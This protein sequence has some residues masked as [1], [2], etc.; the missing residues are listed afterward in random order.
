[1]PMHEHNRG[2]HAA[3]TDTERDLAD[4][5]EVE[6]E[7]IEHLVTLPRAVVSRTSSFM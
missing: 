4:T 1:M 5:D 6:R 7:P 3:V 2:A